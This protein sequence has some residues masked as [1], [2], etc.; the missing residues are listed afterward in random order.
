LSS[1]VAAFIG[2]RNRVL[3][4]FMDGR[5]SEEAHRADLG[6]IAVKLDRLLSPDSPASLEER[7]ARVLAEILAD[8]RARCAAVTPAKAARLEFWQRHRL[9]RLRP[10]DPQGYQAALREE[11][12]IAEAEPDEVR[13]ARPI[14]A[15]L[16][17]ESIVQCAEE[18]VRTMA[19]RAATEAGPPRLPA[20]DAVWTDDDRLS[21]EEFAGGVP[22]QG[23]GRP[24]LGDETRQRDGEP[25]AAYRE[26][27]E[28]IETEFRSRHPEHG[29]SWTVGGGPP[30]CRRCCAPHPLFP[31]QIEQINQILSRH[32]SSPA[33]E[34]PVRRCGTCRKPI[35]G[36]HVCQLADLPKKLRAVVEAVLEQGRGRERTSGT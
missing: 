12:A 31:A 1:T 15:A 25:W 23:C 3:D 30:H 28:P 10:E 19:D 27:M 21:W 33:K 26:R 4:D 7:T 14:L 22:C 17:D 35:E 34:A 6:A 24:F 8:S 11:E 20:S 36:D 16:S 18:R 5:T 9:E 29:T 13:M 2:L 32:M